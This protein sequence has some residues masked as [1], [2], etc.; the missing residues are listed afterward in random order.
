MTNGGPTICRDGS[1][2]LAGQ[3]VAI[4][5]V[6]GVMGSRIALPEDDD[7]WDPD[8]PIT[9]M[10]GWAWANS[11]EKRDLLDFSKRGVII[12]EPADDF[13]TN[14]DA[15]VARGWGG[16]R[17]ASYGA[18]LEVAEG[19][20]FGSNQ[21]PVYAYGYDWRQPVAQIGLQMAADV[22]GVSQ[23][24]GGRRALFDAD[25]F[26]D[27]GL[28]GHA[29]TDKCIFI[30][31]S[32]GG[33]VTRMALQQCSALRDKT[34][35]VLHGVQ[36]ATGGP[37]LY[38][39]MVTG[40]FSPVDGSGF[41]AWVFRNII[42][43]GAGDMSTMLSRCPGPMQL[44][45]G[46]LLRDACAAAGAGMI[47]WTEF[48]ESRATVHAVTESVYNVFRRAE[49]A[50]PPG[51]VRS[52]LPAVVQTNL[53][54]R[55]SGIENF[56]AQLGSWKFED[57]TWAFYGTGLG[58][59]HTI[60]FDCPPVT[61]QTN[62]YSAGRGGAVVIHSATDPSGRT[63]VLD[64]TRDLSRR[65]FNP[66]PTIPGAPSTAPVGHGPHGDET[67]PR[68]SGAGL[69]P[70]SLTTPLPASGT[71]DF[72]AFKQFDAPNVQH[73]PAYRNAGIQRL[74]R[75]WVQYVLSSC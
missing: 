27:S 48:E 55:I 15:R 40:V 47:T 34:V 52:S 58:T 68:L 22:L 29:E 44:L 36:P 50:R 1:N 62:A 17:W 18:F 37:L 14:H 66:T 56:H 31:H 45:P 69:F 43:P 71:I 59:D 23:S 42:G 38:R 28:L 49:T 70:D 61:Y 19:W 2:R 24:S 54:T 33:L 46:N 25:R 9:N 57:R 64:A 12:R 13:S 53:N 72:S 75:Q 63:V 6:H 30:T 3:R 35:A 7:A 51:I 32:M 8:R 4:I 74:T 65:G 20:S 60:H 67:V 26:G 11:T 21:T 73:E 5:F 41:E 39:R 16:V 10:L